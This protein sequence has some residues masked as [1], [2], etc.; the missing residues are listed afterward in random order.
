MFGLY[1]ILFQEIITQIQLPI[2]KSLT[3]VNELNVQNK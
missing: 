3:N 2:I 1:N